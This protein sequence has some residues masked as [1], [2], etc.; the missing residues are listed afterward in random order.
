M[1]RRRAVF[2]Q[3]QAISNVFFSLELCTCYLVFFLNHLGL[4]V[5]FCVQNMPPKQRTI[6]R[7]FCGGPDNI[8]WTPGPTRLRRCNVC[9]SMCVLFVIKK[10]ITCT[11]SKTKWWRRQSRKIDCSCY[12]D[13][14]FPQGKWRTN[15]KGDK[16]KGW[17]GDKVT[18]WKGDSD[19]VE[20]WQGHLFSQAGFVC[21]PKEKWWTRF[22]CSPKK[23]NAFNHS[24]EKQERLIVPAI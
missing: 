10:T 18:R 11:C 15:W 20:G 14:Y 7:C 5:A 1:K 9:N 23:N 16:L 17:R 6:V 3:S 24:H 12:I 8:F 4:C 22:V 19:K 21:P 13:R 2:L